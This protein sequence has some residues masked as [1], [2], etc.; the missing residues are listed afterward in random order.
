MSK[1]LYKLCMLTL[2][3]KSTGAA[4]S[5]AARLLTSPDKTGRKWRV[6]GAE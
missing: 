4:V 6:I 2:Y 1:Y 5:Q 3:F